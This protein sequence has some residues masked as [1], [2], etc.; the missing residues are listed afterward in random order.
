M[1]DEQTPPRKVDAIRIPTG[2]K[3]K[4]GYDLDLQCK[5]DFAEVLGSKR[6]ERGDH[7]SH[8][9]ITSFPRNGRTELF[10]KSDDRSGQSRYE[11]VEQANG[12]EYGYLVPGAVDPA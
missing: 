7:G 2:Y 8:H 9:F 3:G 1:P 4:G 5:L 12:V 6:V 11:W 10:P